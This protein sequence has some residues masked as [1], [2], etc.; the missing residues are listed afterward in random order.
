MG[1]W[2]PAAPAA[3]NL[4]ARILQVQVGSYSGSRQ[5]DIYERKY[6]LYDEQVKS[7]LKSLTI[8]DFTSTEE[9]DGENS[10]TKTVKIFRG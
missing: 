2:K 3:L 1:L 10:W 7:I 5:D 4:W 8:A 6:R 9:K